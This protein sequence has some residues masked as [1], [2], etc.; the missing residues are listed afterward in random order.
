MDQRRDPF[1]DA[2]GVFSTT[3]MNEAGGRP[4]S[5]KVYWLAREE[6][7]RRMEIQTLDE[8]LTPTGPS[9]SVDLETF[10][11]IFEPEPEVF[12]QALLASIGRD[13]GR[14]GDRLRR[15]AA[16]GEDAEL[17]REAAARLEIGIRA[18]F[19]QAMELHARGE[20]GK[21]SD[22]LNRLLRIEAPFE[23]THKH[24]F[25][26]CGIA[27]RKD[28]EFDQAL[29]FYRRAAKLCADDENLFH[30][31]ARVYFE[32]GDIENA[33]RNLRRCLEL[34]PELSEAKRFWRYLQK[35]PKPASPAAGE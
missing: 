2:A 34:N 19:R 23:A 30:N 28:K 15:Q 17:A 18:S 4:G 13:T 10:L 25:N 35:H 33:F 7:E 26:D 9:R 5:R 31:I 8:S 12:V 1:A 22:I 6:P 21:A 24:L 20:I 32:K 29:K 11:Q 14:A 16:P 27:L 3:E